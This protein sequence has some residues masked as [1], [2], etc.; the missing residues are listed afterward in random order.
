MRSTFYGLEIAKTGLFTAQNQLDTT[1]HNMSNAATAGYTRQRVVTAAMPPGYGNTFIAVDYKS[2]AGR[3]VKVLHIEQV[4]NP[5]LDYQYRKENATA[6]K[7][8]TKQQYFEYVESVFNNELEKIDDTTGM[9]RL[10][11]QFAKSLDA[12]VEGGPDKEARTTVKESAIKL[13][14]S[15]NYYYETLLGQQKTLDESIFITVTE[16]NNIVSQVT[17]L[18]R[19][20][21]GIEI[22][23]THANDL[24]DQRNLLLDTLSGLINIDVS[25]D[26]NGQLIVQAGDMTLIRHTRSKTMVA[27]KNVT[28]PIEG[29]PDLYGVYWADS[30]GNASSMA[31]QITS[32]AMRGYF[33]IRDGGDS[34]NPGIPFIVDQMNEI[35]RSI[36]QQMNDVHKTGFT[37][38]ST[39]PNDETR[40]GVLFFHV[41]LDTNNVEDYSTVTAKNFRLSND[42]LT[43]VWNIACSAMPVGKN[44]NGDASDQSGNADVILKMSQI[45]YGG[46]DADGNAVD[47][48]GMFQE[49]LVSIA[50]AMDYINTNAD[51]QTTMRN[52]IEQQRKSISDVSLDEEMSDIVRFSHSYSAASRMITAID[53]ELDTLINK[54]GL[55]GRS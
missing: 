27:E 24:R 33:D 31:V 25:E 51:T 43:D 55:V 41:E 4:R 42:I 52:Y 29:E 23:G 54:M 32:G 47:L 1:A 11:Q 2:T 3:G 50:V 37:T 48:D 20:I 45:L 34:V 49:M 13:T 10:F 36:A 53:E 44:A 8:N 9:T 40:D 6:S 12:I 15:M 46:T 35:C 14:E 18:N 16:I 39:V 30:S 5:F 19:K 22:N 7:W 38:P 26:T 28:N 17:D 21:Y